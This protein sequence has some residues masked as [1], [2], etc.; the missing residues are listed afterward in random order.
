MLSFFRNIDVS[1]KVLKDGSV[2]LSFLCLWFPCSFF[3]FLVC[4]VFAFVCF[5]LCVVF[6]LRCSFLFSSV[7]EAPRLQSSVF[8]N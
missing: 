5:C 3:V 2:F 6:V 7:I 1:E 4:F 8:F